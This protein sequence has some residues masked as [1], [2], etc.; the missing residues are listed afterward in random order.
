MVGTH[1]LV[2]N[3]HEV[4]KVNTRFCTC[5]LAENFRVV[6]GEILVC[7]APLFSGKFSI[8]F[9]GKYSF[10]IDTHYLVDNSMYF[11]VY[12]CNTRLVY[13]LFSGKITK[14]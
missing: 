9:R 1:Y 8:L 10:V 6:Q 2:D 11:R 12:I 3:Y 7:G 5:Y 13:L 14:I 4:Q